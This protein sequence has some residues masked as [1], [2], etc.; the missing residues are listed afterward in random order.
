[1]LI[2]NTNM[3][4]NLWVIIRTMN[5]LQNVCISSYGYVL[6]DKRKD[7]IMITFKNTYT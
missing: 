4:I 7:L 5:S 1:M 2:L 6:L 3:T